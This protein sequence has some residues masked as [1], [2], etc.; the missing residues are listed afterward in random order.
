MILIESV[1]FKMELTAKIIPEEKKLP[2]QY[3]EKYKIKKYLLEQ[4]N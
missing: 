1:K 4:L 2:F 3:G